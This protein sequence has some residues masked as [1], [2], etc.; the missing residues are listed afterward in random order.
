LQ[1]LYWL[2]SAFVVEQAKALDERL[3]KEAGD[4]AEQRIRRAYQLLYARPPDSGEV[5]LGV[6][7]LK[8][9][10]NTWVQYL[11]VLLGAAEFSSVN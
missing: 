6:E 11:Q 2:N 4:N 5:K 3:A 7:Y 1:G 10:A 9:S 8:L